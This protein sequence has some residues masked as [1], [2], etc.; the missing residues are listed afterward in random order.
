MMRSLWSGVSGLQSHQIAMDVEG[1]NIANVNTAGYKYSRANFSDLLSQTSKPATAPEGELGGKNAMQVGLGTQIIS[2]Q[3]IFTQGSLQTTDVWSDMAIQG[4][5]FFVVSP[6]GGLTKYYTRNGAFTRDVLGNFVDSN[7]YIVQGWMRDEDTGTIDPTVPV[8]NINIEPGLSMP[9]NPTTEIKYKGNLNT[10]EHIGTQSAAIYS[11]DS[12]H[13]WFDTSGNGILTADKLFAPTRDASTENDTTKDTLYMDSKNQVR[14][15]ERGVDM[16]VVYDE[17]GD[18][19]NLRDGQG[20]WVSY[21][22]AKATF[23]GNNNAGITVPQDGA[24]LDINING[25]DIRKTVQNLNEVVEAIN[26]YSVQTGVKASVINGT[27]IQLVNSNNTGTTATAKNIKI[28]GNKDNKIQFN[29]QNADAFSAAVITAYQYTYS[30]VGGVATHSYDDS[31]VRQFTTTE[32]LRE[33]MQQDARKYINYDGS[34]LAYDAPQQGGT[35]TA[36]TKWQDNQ[37]YTQ[38]A[39]NN[40]NDGVRVT[41]NAQGQFEINNPAGDAFNEDDYNENTFGQG[42]DKD[43]DVITDATVTPNTTPTNKNTKDDDKIVTIAVTALSNDIVNTNTRME[44]A[45]SNLNGSLSIGASTGKTSSALKMSAHSMTT[46]FYDSLGSKH[47]I[48]V[49]YRKVSYS[50]ENGTEWS[51]MVTVP[52]PGVINLDPEAGAYKNVVT[53]NIRFG[54]DGSLIGYSPSTI[55]YTANNGSAAGQTISLNFGTLGGFDGITSYDEKSNTENIAQDGYTGGTLNGLRID[56][57]GKIIGSFTN[58]HSLALAQVSMATFTN[59]NGLEKLG[60]NV[61]GETANSGAPVIGAA[62]T[63]SRGKINASTLE[64]SNVDLSHAFTQLIVI[65]RGYQANS[66]TITTSD[67]M[68]N[69]LL[70]L[71]Q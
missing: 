55:N 46:E 40:K 6:D 63:G 69:T 41:V 2:T 4:E 19:L 66:K 54:T 39:Y 51:I 17:K 53:G 65:Q 23:A 71:K 13:G 21:A 8:T 49:E 28:Y 52:E 9:A 18:A 48:T 31:A 56:Q 67:N 14:L 60:G 32:D 50:P 20:I 25:I 22:D 47:E 12:N 33:A 1:D 38:E 5:G 42:K 37:G 59:N 45:F 30:S 7:G 57:S 29:G 11:L 26:N 68:L 24:L 70:Q 61:W 27:Q 62:S 3:Q 64:M 43:G 36:A 10:G 58:G 34:L 35:R 44:K 16:G 15:R